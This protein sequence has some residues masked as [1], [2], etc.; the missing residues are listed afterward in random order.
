MRKQFTLVLALICFLYENSS[1]QIIINEGSNK[2]Y[3][4]VAD[5]DGDSEDWIELYNNT[6]FPIDL[7]GYS[8]TD[9]SSEPRQWIFPQFY[10][11]AG[12][13][14][15]V[16]CSEKDRFS[17]PP[18]IQTANITSF[19]PANNWNTH[20]MSSPFLWDGSSN[21]I[22]NICSYDGAYTENSVFR[23][24]ATAYASSLAAF[25]DY[26]AAAC[27]APT[28]N[29]YFQR[30]NLRL[31]GITI[32]TG[33]VQNGTTDYPAPYGNWYWGARHQL[34][35]PA[36]ELIAAGLNA[37]PINTLAF[38]VVNPDP[39]Q[40]DYIEI[41]MNHSTLSSLTTNFVPLGGNNF[42]T[43]FKISSS[44]E[45]V[46]LYNP[47]GN[48]ESSLFV[49]CTETDVS[50]GSFPDGSSNVVVFSPPTPEATNNNS[51]ALSGVALEPVFSQ[52]SQVRGT[53]MNVSISN[54]NPAGSEIRY[55]TDGSDPTINSPLYDTVPVFVFQNMVLKARAFIPGKVPS[56]IA[57][58]S[59]LINMSHQ[60]P[61]LSLYTDPAN[62]YGP[63]GNFDNPFRD[64]L[65]SVQVDY[66]AAGTGHPLLFKKRSG[67]IQDGGAGGSRGAPQRSFR[68]ELDHNVIGEGAVNLPLIPRRPNRNKYSKLYFRNGSNQ[69]LV[70][71]YKDAA[72][73]T[74]MAGET[75]AYYSAMQPVS[76]YV[77]GQYFGL[78]EMREKFDEEY[79]DIYDNADQDKVDILSLSYYYNSVL[80][81]V[82]G[83]PV[84]SFFTA[85]NN[86]LTFSRTDTAYWSNADR[87]FDMKYYADYVIA[88]TWM[89]NNDWPQNN[90]KIYRSDATQ[91]RYRFCVID[92]ELAMAPNGWTDCQYDQIDRLLN[93]DPGNPYINIW[94]RSIQNNRF[95]DYFIN[96]AAD[97]M[98][99]SYDT[100]RL[101]SI[102]RQFFNE[103]VVEMPKEYERWG[104]A[105]IQQQM[106]DFYQA[107]LDLDEELICRS[108]QLRDDMEAGFNL[109]QQVEVELDVF[110]ANSGKINISTVSPN[111][112]PVNWIY[113]DGVPVKIEAVA[114]PGY[115]FSHWEPNGLIADTL[116]P[117]FL[118]TL[119]SDLLF[120]AYFEA[121]PSFVPESEDLERNFSLFPNPAGSSINLKVENPNLMDNAQYEIISYDGRVVE[122]GVLSAE[123][124][125][126][127]SIG[128]LPAGLYFFRILDKSVPF[129]KTL[130]FVKMRE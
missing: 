26:S 89:P 78:Y 70:M 58:V 60:T 127:F 109:P 14:K 120:K 95:R 5:E 24:T 9:R 85:Y 99:T 111:A 36:S 64:W 55:T 101:L 63:N 51:Q 22:I 130:K 16:F 79:F 25:E 75:N 31:N 39:C 76:V 53:P 20:N 118:D 54:P 93:F 3:A 116:Q 33:N 128:H 67:M 37:G 44:G 72:Q 103:M 82:E 56:K 73:V 10:L 32:G 91:N 121:I 47:A 100:S 77:N 123:N 23:Q 19:T 65:K 94:K 7:Q 69:F 83:D 102:N 74:M 87:I 21:L 126:Y 68:L 122:N 81:S 15:L 96:R 115:R 84:D 97:L 43:N 71:P 92:Q 4:T 80:R 50:K 66:F 6:S 2:N 62:L 88:N 104:T 110:P 124:I 30:P 129:E 49:N 86:F 17:S 59:Y 108:Q 61:I 40:Y 98:N 45:T 112:Y 117:L 113:F 8:L 90:I 27:D 52:P 18:F 34:L 1:A 38:N 11:P 13:H 106:S 42:H 119:S 57:G 12:A 41:S 107:Y 114:K 48:L 28:G 105:N 35:I 46:L 125:H 29:V